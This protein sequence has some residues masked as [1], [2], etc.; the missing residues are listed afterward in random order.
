MDKKKILIVDDEKEMVEMEAMRLA[1]SGYEVLTAYDGE[2]GLEIAHR[3]KPDIILLDIMLPK[4][5]GY[6]VCA[7]LKRDARYGKIPIILVTAV[8]QNYDVDLGKQVGADFYV[9]KPFEP[10][11]LLA[12]IKE[13][14]RK[15]AR[16]S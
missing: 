6:L 2:S 8:D 14:I 3:E 15:P 1:A 11:M 10:K 7:K 4:M 13:L 16:K 9:M 5:D 12:K